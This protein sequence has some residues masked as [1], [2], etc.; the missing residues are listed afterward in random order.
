M[1][2]NKRLWNIGTGTGSFTQWAQKTFM[3]LKKNDWRLRN[4]YE[5]L[6]FS[7]LNEQ[8]IFILISFQK[9][10]FF[11]L[12]ASTIFDYVYFPHFSDTTLKFEELANPT[13]STS[14]TFASHFQIS[15]KILKLTR[16]LVIFTIPFFL[17]P[18]ITGRKLMQMELKLIDFKFCAFKQVY[19]WIIFFCYFFFRF[20]KKFCM[21]FATTH[22]H[23][24]TNFSKYL[25]SDANSIC[26]TIQI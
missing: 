17:L 16:I 22:I 3:T 18:I 14:R 15:F 5:M 9:L 13:F 8:L 11:V 1:R 7:F 4:I 26:V 20:D 2:H 21:W 10:L 19:E 25:N 12:F 24:G 23:N 6:S